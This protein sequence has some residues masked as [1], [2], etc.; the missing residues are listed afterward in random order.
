MSVECKKINAKKFE[1]VSLAYWEVTGV[2]LQFS[3]SSM[4]STVFFAKC[5]PNVPLILDRAIIGLSD[6]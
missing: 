1:S 2:L 6:T 4:S 3:N 5:Y